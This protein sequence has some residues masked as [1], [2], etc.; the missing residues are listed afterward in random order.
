[1]K[2]RVEKMLD[3]EKYNIEREQALR[4]QVAELADYFEDFIR[5]NMDIRN[6]PMNHIADPDTE[7]KIMAIPIRPEGRDPKEVGDELVNLVFNA[8]TLTNHPRFFSFVTS[9]VSPYSVAGEILS[10]LY[11]S[12]MCAYMLACG[13]VLVEEK[14]IRWA[15]GRAGFDPELCG[16]VFTSGGSLSNLTGMIC[17]REA[18]LPGRYDLAN[19]VAFCSD[20]AHSSVRKG[21]R[22]MGLRNDQI[23]IVDSDDNFRIRTDILRGEIEKALAEGKKPFLL[24]GSC[25]TTNT[26]SIDPLNELADIAEK[27]DLWLHV[28]GA[29]GGSIL[30]SDIYK[31]LAKGL[32]RADSFS[33]DF[34]KWALQTYSCSCVIAKDKNNLLNAFAEHPE[35]LADIVSTEHNDG[36]DLGIEMSRPARSIK[37]WYTLQAMGTDLMADVIDYSFFNASLAAKRFGEAEDWRL[38]SKPSCGTINVRYEPKGVDPALYDKLN[39]RISAEIIGS[40]Y[41]YIVTTVLKGQ[42]CL[43]IIAINGN[44]ETADVLNTVDKIKEIAENLRASL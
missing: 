6:M 39:E 17:G 36:W 40:G 37:L 2:Q 22:M 23:V 27:Y 25:G 29:Y 28:D 31:N 19:A 11:N 30:I 24:V 43:R 18:K 33:W 21:M 1:M 42:R 20:Q 9:A 3:R 44:T 13:P 10:A 8:A 16:G 12:N 35:Y 38:I 34:H 41:A 7:K 14:L 4:A 5:K 15:G 32:E 26:G